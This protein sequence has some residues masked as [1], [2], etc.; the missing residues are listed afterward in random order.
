MS[1]RQY[2]PDQA[3]AAV[4]QFA[5]ML[6]NTILSSFYEGLKGA[7]RLAITV[8]MDPSGGKNA[9]VLPNKIRVRS[10]KLR[11]GVG[12]FKP[13]REGENYV[14]GLQA[15]GP[16]SRIHEKG[17]RTGPHTILP[18]R[19]KVLTWIDRQ[20]GERV[21]RRIVFHPGSNIPARPYLEPALLMA[22]DQIAKR[23]DSGIESTAN[24]VI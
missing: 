19:G 17:G 14:G 15:T 4:L 7:H 12:I 24:Q 22:K 18:I 9:P 13:R 11:R 21:F 3:A 16:Y 1:D 10:G 2:T 20:S 8:T 6:P 23:I 5:K